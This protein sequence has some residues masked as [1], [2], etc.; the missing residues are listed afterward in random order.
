MFKIQVDNYK[1]EYVEKKSIYPRFGTTNKYTHK[2]EVKTNK[3]SSSYIL[4]SVIDDKIVKK[5]LLSH[6]M[7]HLRKDRKKHS[8]FVEEF[9]ANTYGMINNPLGFIVCLIMSLSWDRLKFYFNQV[10]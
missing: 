4:G 5:F 7:F 6:E 1:V 9:L 2:P 10:W 8:W 3:K